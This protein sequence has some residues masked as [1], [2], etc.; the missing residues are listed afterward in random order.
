MFPLGTVLFPRMPLQLHVFE[1]RYRQLVEDL[2][3][4]AERGQPPELG[5]VL[6]ERGAEVGG[7]D[8]RFGLGAL[9]RVLEV[10]RVADGRYA[11]VGAGVG[12]VRVQA[13]LPDDP[14]PLADVDVLDDLVLD[15]ALDG[16]LRARADEAVRRCLDRRA[17]LG[18]P[19]WPAVVAMAPVPDAALWQ[20]AAI[21]P[22]GPLD[23]QALLGAATATEL[24]ARLGDLAEE[25]A[26][27]LAYRLAN[28]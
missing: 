20:L 7:G 14:Y 19:T 12:R 17:R 1:L 13:W 21:A 22:L 25:E 4:G 26:S 8:Q 15:E 18:A 10:G 27:V 5:V 6:I 9:A 16:P 23:H 3:A 24:L 11:L 2:L 28:G